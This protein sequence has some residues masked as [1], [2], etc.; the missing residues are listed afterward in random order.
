MGH[1]LGPG[2]THHLFVDVH[3]VLELGLLADLAHVQRRHQAGEVTE[4][5]NQF[6]EVSVQAAHLELGDQQREES[7][8][9]MHK[10]DTFFVAAIAAQKGD[11]ISERL[12]LYH[13]LHVLL[14]VLVRE[15]IL[16]VILD[17]QGGEEIVLVLED[18]VLVVVRHVCG[19]D[20]PE[21]GHL[22]ALS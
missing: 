20:G 4:A 3:H 9:G 15:K 8:L 5:Q 17:T 19:Q 22:L 2:L 6:S 14:L 10:D 11:Q 16:L 12:L 18:E 13:R 21:K 7:I 1:I